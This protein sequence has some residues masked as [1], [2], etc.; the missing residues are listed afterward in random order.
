MNVLVS[1]NASV[2]LKAYYCHLT[3]AVLSF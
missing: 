1:R 2:A 3:M